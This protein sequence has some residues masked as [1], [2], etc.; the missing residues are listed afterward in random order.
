MT[1]AYALRDEPPQRELMTSGVR[2]GAG[3]I[4][5][6]AADSRRGATDVSG[7]VSEAV[8]RADIPLHVLM[9]HKLMSNF[10]RVARDLRRPRADAP[11][12]D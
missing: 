3:R 10:H 7:A 5:W 1:A 11:D 4:S 2:Y 9:S 12:S 6:Y 8:V